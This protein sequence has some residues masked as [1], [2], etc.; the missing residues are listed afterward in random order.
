MFEP[1]VWIQPM[2]TLVVFGGF[3]IGL[4]RIVTAKLDKK[5]DREVCHLNIKHLTEKVEDTN[6]KVADIAED[7]KEILK[8]NGGARNG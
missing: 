3:C 8:R 2:A 1:T 6:V 4:F 5:V 7:T